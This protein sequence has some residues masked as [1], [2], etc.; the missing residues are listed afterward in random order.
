MILAELEA[1]S[2]VGST[3][4]DFSGKLLKANIHLTMRV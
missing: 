2:I 4:I 3:D 1:R